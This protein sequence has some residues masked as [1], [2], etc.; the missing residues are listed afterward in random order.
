MNTAPAPHTRPTRLAKLALTGLLLGAT[1]GTG[2]TVTEAL[3]QAAEVAG[4]AGAAFEAEGVGTLQN[5]GLH[6]HD[7]KKVVVLRWT[8]D[9][10]TDPDAALAGVVA[11]MEPQLAPYD[12]D[13]L[14]FVVQ[15]ASKFDIGVVS[16]SKTRRLHT[17]TFGAP[18]SEST[19]DSILDD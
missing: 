17:R 7:D 11:R 10:H 13:S 19:I 12:I 15:D 18:L 4:I 16:V 9:G 8:P 2:C 1:S 6:W 14:L 3:K 5:V